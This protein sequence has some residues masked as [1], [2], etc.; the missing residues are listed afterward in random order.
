M[1]YRRRPVWL[2]PLVGE[3]RYRIINWS[4]P[5]PYESDEARAESSIFD[6]LGRGKV[7]N[8][9]SY[10]IKSWQRDNPLIH[11]EDQLSAQRYDGTVGI[12]NEHLEVPF[13]VESTIQDLNAWATIGASRAL[14][15]KPII[16]LPVVIGE[17]TE[18][19]QLG[20]GAAG[21]VR[22]LRRISS[23]KTDFLEKLADAWKGAGEATLYGL[24][25][26]KPLVEVV[27]EMLNY[28]AS[29]DRELNRLLTL[30]N[31]WQHF[32]VNL[33]DDATSSSEDLADPFEPASTFLTWVKSTKAVAVTTRSEKIW[34][35]GYIRLN[36]PEFARPHAREMELLKRLHGIGP[37]DAGTAA[38]VLYELL[39]F[40]WLV[41]WFTSAGALAK[42]ASEHS[43]YS[44]KMT[45]IMHET[46]YHKKVDGLLRYWSR[47]DGTLREKFQHLGGEI[48]VTVKR[49][50][51][52][53][54][55]TFGLA[56]QKGDPFKY[57]ILAALA[58]K[59]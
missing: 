25:G 3:S 6:E 10:Q 13:G 32:Q 12:S 53:A 56:T 16:D 38:R 39:P 46:D 52:D 36:L 5:I 44:W 26:V 11:A 27:A 19:R 49:R 37:S 41:D 18:A 50:R 28:Q 35:E 4:D 51:R 45:C 42:L 21:L 54:L 40:S 9:H 20:T 1:R 59:H 48:R 30:A 43:A 47:E 22:H 23:S 7:N 2:T 58:A 8:L 24:F 15:L 31:K 55:F 33:L 57:A 34:Y 17:A 14:L 29:I